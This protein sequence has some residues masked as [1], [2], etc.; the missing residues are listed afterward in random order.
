MVFGRPRTV[1]TRRRVATVCAA[2]LA[3]AAAC[4]AAYWL[5]ASV[6]A[7]KLVEL[8]LERLAAPASGRTAR[9]GRVRV[10]PFALALELDD[11]EIA[12]PSAEFRLAARRVRIDFS[13]RSLFAMR[14]W[15]D[16]LDIR[17][18][19]V[20]AAA[21]TASA[22]AAWSTL[23]TLADRVRVAQLDAGIDSIAGPATGETRAAVRGI[24]VHGESLG[25]GAAG[26]RLSLAALD[27]FGRGSRLNVELAVE[28]VAAGTRLRGA[29]ALTGA[30]FPYGDWAIAAPR[31]EASIDA[32]VSSQT[33]AVSVA[34]RGLPITATEADDGQPSFAARDSTVHATWAPDRG[35]VAVEASA[36]LDRGGR[37]DLQLAGAPDRAPR[38][39]FTLTGVPVSSLAS[40]ARRALGAQPQSGLI[41]LD[42]AADGTE[43][44]RCAARVIGHDLRLAPGNARA[45]RAIAS[46]EAPDGQSEIDVPLAAGTRWSEQIVEGVR[47]TITMLDAAPYA[48]LVELVGRD[49]ATLRAVEFTAGT[50]EPTAGGEA[51]LDALAA[52][53]R[54]RPRIGVAMEPSSDQ[55]LDR[56]A[57]AREQVELHVRLATASAGSTSRAEAV[58][59]AS[60]RVQDVLDEFARQRLDA[61]ELAPIASRFGPIGAAP[62]DAPQRVAYYR[63]ILEALVAREPIADSAL[64]R[65]AQFRSRAL[66]AAFGARG[67]APS[68]V[69]QRAAER[70]EDEDGNAVFLPLSVR[71]E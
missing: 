30:D 22:A 60:P 66:A 58:D 19:T 62:L 71:P 46:L 31:A 57:L 25:T 36:W 63:A 34:A 50:A 32:T 61:D 39:R 21:R 40:F 68:R 28:P 20:R 5:S 13:W 4:A 17:G 11:V 8:A 29:A 64:R 6:A 3:A 55:A 2:G 69:V 7:P 49:A 67:I 18:G 16:S 23:Q 43:P 14:P 15:L 48:A 9:A 38:L 12:V 59:L 47:Q 33:V 24:A 54:I 53:L 41:D 35:A 10:A 37:A 51:S 1:G 44:P 70:A 52:A 26:G 45:A 56:A 65:L 27:T 42:V